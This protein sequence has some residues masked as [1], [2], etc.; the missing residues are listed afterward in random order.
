MAPV[1]E[2]FWPQYE[3]FSVSFQEFSSSFGSLFVKYETEWEI[4]IYF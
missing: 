3:I 4:D 2:I 1:T